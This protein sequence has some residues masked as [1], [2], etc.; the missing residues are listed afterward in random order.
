MDEEEDPVAVEEADGAPSSRVPS[1]LL[2]AV[3]VRVATV[4]A[5]A[6]S[7]RVRAVRADM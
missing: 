4:S 2:H 6:A 7:R 1:A 5:A 3:I